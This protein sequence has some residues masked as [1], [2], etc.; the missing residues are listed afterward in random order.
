MK[1]DLFCEMLKKRIPGCLRNVHENARGL[2]P[3]DFLGFRLD[4]GNGFCAT[5][6]GVCV[7]EHDVH[8]HGTRDYGVHML[9][10]HLGLFA[11]ADAKTAKN[12]GATLT[13]GVDKVKRR[14]VNRRFASG[15]TCAECGVDV[16][17]S[18]QG[19]PWSCWVR[20]PGCFRGRASCKLR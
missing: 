7:G 20:P 18:F 19:V 12:L 10:E 5:F 15:S 3:G 11:I 8:E 9:R 2:L 16:L 17:E 13:D 14:L 1:T 6:G 4:C